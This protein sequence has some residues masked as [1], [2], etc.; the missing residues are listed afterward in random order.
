MLSGEKYLYLFKILEAYFLYAMVAQSRATNPKNVGLRPACVISLLWSCRIK[1]K[2]T[3][4]SILYLRNG[5]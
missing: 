3:H 1:H 5:P 2:I 4:F